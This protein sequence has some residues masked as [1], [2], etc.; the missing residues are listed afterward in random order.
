MKTPLTFLVASLSLLG[1]TGCK[2]QNPVG[3]DGSPSNVVFP[4]SGVSYQ[5]QVQPLFNQACNFS[6]CHGSDAPPNLVKLTSW[7]ELMTSGAGAGVVVVG[8]PESST[9][10]LR[11]EGRGA[12]MPP[13]G[14]PL[15]QNQINGIRAWIAEG[16]KN[17]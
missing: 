16:A 11:I 10:V 5:Y 17:N 14:L 7:G 3:E 1:I 15:N 6:G 13:S 12:R 9:L 8:Q 2:D 4:T